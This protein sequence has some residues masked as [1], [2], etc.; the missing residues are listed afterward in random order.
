MKSPLLAASALTLILS[1]PSFAQDDASS[2]DVTVLDTITVTTPLRRET[3]LLRSTSSVSVLTE[4]DIKRSAASDLPALLR[5]VAGISTNGGMGARAA[6]SI[7]GAKSTQTLVLINGVNVKSATAGEASVF[8][9]PLDAIERIEVAKGAHSAQYGS[10]AIGGV[11]N[12]ITKSGSTCGKEICTTISGGVSYPW[13]GS[14]G[15]RFGG[16]TPDGATFSLGGRVIGTRGYNFTTPD[17]VSTYE[18]DDDGFLQGSFDFRFD[19]ELGWGAVYAAGAYA[20]ARTEYDDAGMWGGDAADNDLFSG[21]VGARFDHDED[22]SSTVELSGALDKQTNFRKE[23][24]YEDQFD[25]QRLGILA[26][27]E[28]TF[29]FGEAANTV[30]F[31]G[32]FVRE[33]VDS[34]VAYEV[35]SRDLAAAFV[36]NSFEYN[37]LTLDAGLRYD[38]NEQFG[39]ATTYNLGASYELVPGL[40][41]RASYGTGFRAPTFNDLYYPGWANPNLK[42]EE[43]KTVEVGLRWQPTNHTSFDVALYE[44]RLRNFF[45]PLAGGGLVNVDAARI[46]GVEATVTHRFNERWHAAL[47]LDVRDPA[48]LTT[49]MDLLRQ[50]RV[51]ASLEVGFRATDKLSLNATL[52]YGGK[53]DDNDPTTWM[54]TTLPAYTTLDFT[55]IYDFDE[56]TQFKLS[57]ENL[58]DEDYSTSAGYR[59]PGRTINVGFTRTF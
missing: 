21:K 38:H 49:G 43:S 23:T 48:D 58:F 4:E 35:T 17:N 3:S 54:R 9:I 59:S 55:A 15:L 46:R 44:T 25:T 32:E 22:W 16:T 10:D 2:D 24:S 33:S 18:P 45:N 19:K 5:T 6:V 34:S 8:N 13:G 36:Q 50:E 51:K 26:S 57:V 1:G 37:G 12:I 29:R 7:R 39:E 56:N 52:I 42:P 27:T 14:A 53:R 28:K 31:G 40:V 47:G 41:A 20:R 11:I 30:T